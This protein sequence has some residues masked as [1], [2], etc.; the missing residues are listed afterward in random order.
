MSA[1]LSIGITTRDRPA[2]LRAAVA[3]LDVLAALSLEILVFDDGSIV[4]AE[5][6]LGALASRVR[7]LRDAAAPG[8]IVGRNRLVREASA[9]FVL[10]LDDDARLL[11]AAS[12]A[13]AMAIID[14]DPEVAAVAF[15]QAEAD[16]APWPAPMQP[17]TARE[18]VVVPAF[19]GFAHLLR[20]S[21]FLQLGGYRE[22]FGAFGEE[23]DYC[24]RLLDHGLRAVYLPD[25]LVAHVP[26]PATRNRQRY[27]RYVV[28]ND[29]LHSIYNDP[30]AR[31]IWVAPSRFLLYFRMRRAWRISDPW[32]WAWIVREIV[33]RGPTAMAER[34]PVSWRTLTRW[35]ALRRAH[36]AYVGPSEAHV[37]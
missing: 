26:D 16:G 14:A 30:L 25:A 37:R 2:S 15:A 29:V 19:I 4:P 9:P 34:R 7:V 22:V 12:V 20:R 6:Q 11:N 13:R 23:K 21:T 8:Y 35:R 36:V 17:S 28:R 24:L 1:T 18:A 5:E 31:L 3:S 32:G 10:L 33:S 27:L